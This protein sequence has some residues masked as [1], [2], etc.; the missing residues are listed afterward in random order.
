MILK[1]AQTTIILRLKTL[2]IILVSI[3]LF[4]I[5]IF[6]LAIT[7]YI[8]ITITLLVTLPIT[9]TMPTL[10]MCIIT[11]MVSNMLHIY[12]ILIYHTSVTFYLRGPYGNRWMTSQW[13]C[14][15]QNRCQIDR[16]YA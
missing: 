5:I 13:G 10:T 14:Q 12:Y 15:N 11:T 6:F 2:L 3:T 7:A 4:P 8:T 1:S 16:S 9:T